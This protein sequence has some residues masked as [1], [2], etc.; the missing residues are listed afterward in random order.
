M[1]GNLGKAGQGRGRVGTGGQD[2]LQPQGPGMGVGP[3]ALPHPDAPIGG[4]C[5]LTLTIVVREEEGLSLKLVS[6]QQSI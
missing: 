6:E 1:V 2:R 5:T 3:I 4:Q